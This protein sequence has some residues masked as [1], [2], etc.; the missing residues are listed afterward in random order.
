MTT[1]TTVELWPYLGLRSLRVRKVILGFL[2]TAV[3]LWGLR[4]FIRKSECAVSNVTT[5]ETAELIFVG[6]HE[7]S[8][9]G[10]MRVMLDAHPQIRCG[11]EPMITL[12]L[13]NARHSMSEGKRQRGIQAGVFPEA[14]DQAIA[15]F[16]LKTVEKMGPPADYLCHKQPMTHVYMKY[17]AVLFPKAKFIHMLRDGRAVV[18]SSMQRHLIGN[19]TKQNMHSWNNLV[20]TFLRDCNHLGPQRCMTMRYESL[21]LDP[22][23][24]T[25]RLFAFLTIPWD[26]IVLKHH[27]MLEKLTHLNPFEPSTKQLRRAIHSDSLGK[28]AGA[29]YL[30]KNPFMR[31][32]HGE[33]PL[34]RILGYAKIGIPPNYRNLPVTLP[35]LV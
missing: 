17:L 33:I 27:T 13:L 1:K 18:A 11:A 19:N 29:D 21:I 32:A 6:G 8:G 22:E 34:L 30:T 14:F 12:D 3:T 2:C 26:P 28:W 4:K 23:I 31:V 15:A 9:T 10:L 7:S 24:E 16:I 35:E 20:T 5:A 25:R